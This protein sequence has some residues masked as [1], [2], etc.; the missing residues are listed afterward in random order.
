[1]AYEDL[2]QNARRGTNN[3]SNRAYRIKLWREKFPNQPFHPAYWSS[4]HNLDTVQ[5]LIVP[6]VYLHLE[7][8]PLICLPS[9]I[10]Y[11][12]NIGLSSHFPPSELVSVS[13]PD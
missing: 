1:M 10:I 3:D 2:I 6:L 5:N 13:G 11:S 7:G 9:F 4:L 12:P 8:P